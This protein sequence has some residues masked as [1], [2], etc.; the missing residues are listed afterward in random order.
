MRPAHTFA[1]LG[2][3]GMMSELETIGEGE[4]EEMPSLRKGWKVPGLCKGWELWTATCSHRVAPSPVVLSLL[5]LV[6][7]AILG[8]NPGTSA[9]L[10]K[11]VRLLSCVRL[12]TTPWTVTY[13]APLSMGFS[14]QEDWKGLP[15]PPP[16]DLPDPGIEPRFPAL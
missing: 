15:F 2:L 9:V 13:C 7:Q 3:L 4:K 5:E 10:V 1:V 8:G 11:L 6:V 14:R 16:E 12:F